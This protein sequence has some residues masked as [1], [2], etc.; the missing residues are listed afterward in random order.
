MT[1][2]EKSREIAQSYEDDK[3]SVEDMVIACI[4]ISKWKDEQNKE[5]NAH[6]IDWLEHIQ[7][8][9]SDRKNAGGH[10]MSEQHTL[11]E[12]RVLAKDAVFYIKNNQ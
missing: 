3:I 10:T 11:D 7:Q 4:G 5:L 12:I 9:A 6:I 2:E 8:L 1:N